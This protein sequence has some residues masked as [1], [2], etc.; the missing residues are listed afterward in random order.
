[1]MPAH[2]REIEVENVR[3]HVI[4]I[5]WDIAYLD[6]RTNFNLWVHNITS[7]AAHF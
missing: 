2:W 1:M 3:A 7:L 4:D 5:S 6:A